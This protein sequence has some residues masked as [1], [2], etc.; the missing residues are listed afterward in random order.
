[1]DGKPNKSR[2]RV[3]MLANCQSFYASVEKAAH[4]LNTRIA[5]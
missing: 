1:M 3:I 4:T 2:E 5:R